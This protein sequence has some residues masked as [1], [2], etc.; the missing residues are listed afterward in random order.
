MNGHAGYRLQKRPATY[1]VDA[2]EESESRTDLSRWRL[3]DER[4]R[5]R[6]KYL[7]TKKEAE[8]WPQSTAD[9]FHL[10]L[11]LVSTYVLTCESPSKRYLGRRE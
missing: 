10:G 2:E 6:W 1:T 9:R 8:E 7:R 4:G 5:Q 11:S 3:L